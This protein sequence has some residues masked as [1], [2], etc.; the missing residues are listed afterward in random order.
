M[1]GS[2]PFDLGARHVRSTNPDPAD[3]LSRRGSDGGVA[4]GGAVVGGVVVLV[5][6]VG[7]TVV[8]VV[9]ATVVEV[10]GA[11]VVEVVGGVVGG[12][13]DDVV[14]VVGVSVPGGGVGIAAPALGTRFM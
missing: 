10:V 8:E 7:A 3:S 12:V 1:I 13:V 4:A 2:P 14:E 11:T 5:D 6:V 9:G